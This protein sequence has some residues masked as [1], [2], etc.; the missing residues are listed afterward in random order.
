MCFGSWIFHFVNVIDDIEMKNPRAVGA[1]HRHVGM[2]TGIRKIEIDF[3]ADE[4][5]HDHMFARRSESQSSLVF[6]NVAG[7]LKFFQVT[8]VNLVAL[9]LKIWTKVAA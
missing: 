8:L 5:V 3:P 9:T 2:R 1:A 4:I 6:K 7:V